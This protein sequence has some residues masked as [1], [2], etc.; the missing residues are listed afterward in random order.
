MISRSALLRK[1]PEQLAQLDRID[2]A[3]PIFDDRG[4]IQ[5]YPFEHHPLVIRKQMAGNDMR[6]RA[7]ADDRGVGEFIWSP[8]VML[9]L[10]RAS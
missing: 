5:R 6:G 10:T 1:P 4:G 9:T 8:W 3:T 2:P 7:N